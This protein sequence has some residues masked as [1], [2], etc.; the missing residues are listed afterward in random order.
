MF[1]VVKNTSYNAAGQ[2]S[3]CTIDL[4]RKWGKKNE[5]AQGWR[6]LIFW[7]EL[8]D[9]LYK[10]LLPGTIVDITSGG[11]LKYYKPRRRRI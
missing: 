8:A 3:T 10:L 7:G 9:A 1:Y 6:S 4:Q 11:M 2:P 5:R